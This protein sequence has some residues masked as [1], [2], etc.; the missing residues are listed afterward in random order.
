[1]A[2]LMC[3]LT[4]NIVNAQGEEAAGASAEATAPVAVESAGGNPITDNGEASE[5]VTDEDDAG[6]DAEGSGEE[7]EEGNEKPEFVPLIKN[8]AI[9]LG[10]L[11]GILGF[12]FWSSSSEWFVFKAFYKIVPMLLLCY[13]LPSLLTL[14]RVV[15]PEESKLYFV[16]SRYLLPAS[17]VL[18]TLSIDL[19][20]ILGLG[21]KALIM[22]LTGSAGVVFGGPIAILLFQFFAPDVVG[23]EGPEAVWRGLSTV[24]G[25]WIGG[26]ANQ[27]AMKEIFQPSDDL[28]GAMVTV[29]V[30]VAEFWM[31]FLLLGVGK[32]KQIDRFFNADASSV[33][34][35]QEKMEAFQVQHARNPSTTDLFVMLAIGFGATAIAHFGSELITPVME[36][37]NESLKEKDGDLYFWLQLIATSV[38]SGFFWLIVL[39]TT[40]GVA[41]SF[42]PLRR[43]E[44]AGAS[45]IGTIFIFILV[46]TIGLS[47]DLTA[48][49]E[50][51]SLFLVGLLWMAIHVGLLAGVGYLIRAPY[52][53]LAVGSKANIGGA[54]SAPVVAAAF[55]PS[56]APV[57]VLLA[58]LGYV[59]GTYGAWLCAIMMRLAAGDVPS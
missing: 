27:A 15:N 45:K 57:G 10:L 37:W 7:A 21:P 38:S 55:H 4:C 39:A 18:L 35:L 33:E 54:A 44:G 50:Y 19:K 43:L 2:V 11:I 56:L 46:A 26:G 52:F 58:V 42:T 53:F 20:A 25:S 34:R 22:F 12:V 48:I 51:A 31:M 6:T 28:Y 9:V 59:L 23:G 5:T 16:A 49:S 13:F 29:D 47:M 36:A 8:D 1:M 32:A 41:L 3:L 24:A 17:I 14:G 40:L 30:L